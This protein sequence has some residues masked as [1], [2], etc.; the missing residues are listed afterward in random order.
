MILCY[1]TFKIIIIIC[2]ICKILYYY[3]TCYLLKGVPNQ[4]LT[5]NFVCTLHGH[6]ALK[7][8][9]LHYDTASISILCDYTELERNCDLSGL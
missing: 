9:C 6:F 4:M 3:I 7:L 2:H 5:K 8:N 1:G